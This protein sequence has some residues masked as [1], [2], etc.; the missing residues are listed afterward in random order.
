MSRTG[1]TVATLTLAS[2]V[3]AGAAHHSNA[4]EPTAVEQL[5][6]ELEIL[7]E[8]LET[9]EAAEAAEE[10]RIGSLEQAAE[11]VTS[12]DA[13]R[14]VFGDRPDISMME[15]RDKLPPAILPAVS[16]GVDG[17]SLQIRGFSHVQWDVEGIEGDGGANNFAIG[18][19]DL[20]ITS[21]IAEKVSFL[22]ETVFEFG[23][24]G[25]NILDVERVLLRY[26]YAEGLN[27]TAG[28]G[29]TPLGYW[30]QHYHHGTWLQTTT[31]R[32]I[33]YR[34]EDD[35]GILPVH[36]V[37]LQLDGKFF[38]DYGIFTYEALVS[39]GRGTI[40][41][42]VQLVEDLNDAKRIAFNTSFEPSAVPGL[43][44]GGMVLFDK[45]PRDSGVMNREDSAKE[46]IA[47]G[48][49]VYLENDVELLVEG[50]Y[51]RHDNRS[52]DQIFDHWGGYA[53]LA[54]SFG[55][56]KPYYR[57]DLLRIEG[58]DPFYQNEM[59]MALDEVEDQEQH[60]MGV[61]WDTATYLALKME[62][63][64]NNARSADIHSGTIQASF[65]F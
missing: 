9:L 35:G 26:E 46:L 23:E 59:G 22:N 3:L 42:S 38:S 56:I 29:H 44:F 30:N 11:Q 34:F 25:E 43:S 6:S 65:A 8:R 63:R 10:E 40:P 41:D 48:H 57:F 39:N 16:L 18:G 1:N 20:F 47:G 15:Q 61:R 52:V 62:Y 21:Q 36:Y 64:Y 53:Q 51:I 54:Y 12:N 19:V 24:G 14:V 13:R 50:F 33:I 32:P 2:L 37:G 49:L 28:R 5:Q 4:G 55:D 58:G 45:I 17:P 60:T 7:R 31:D 27:A